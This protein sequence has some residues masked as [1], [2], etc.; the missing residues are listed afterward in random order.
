MSVLLLA[1]PPVVLML[2]A[3]RHDSFLLTCG[4]AGALF[5]SLLFVGYARIW[6]PP[7]CGSVIIITLTALAWLWFGV[8]GP[9]TSFDHLCRAILLSLAI[10]LLIAND[11]TRS[12]VEARRRAVKLCRK[13]QERT[14]WP[15]DKSEFP[16]LPEVRALRFVLQDTPESAIRLFHDPRAEVRLSLFLALQSRPYWRSNEAAAV[17]TAIK[18]ETEPDVRAEGIRTL[19]EANDTRVIA[20]V[21]GFLRDPSP[22]VR[23]AVIQTLLNGPAEKWYLVRETIRVAMADPKFNTEGALP[24]SAGILAPIATIDLFNWA[25]ENEPLGGRATAT[26]VAHYSRLLCDDLHPSL[27][28]EICQ[29]IIDPTTPPGLRIELAVMMRELGL[30]L[31]QYLDR[32]TDIDQPSPL[33]LMAVETLL[34]H[35]PANADAI[36]VLRGLARH[37]N[38]ETI[39]EVARLLQTYLRIDMGLTQRS[40]FT[41]RH[42]AEVTRLVNNWARNHKQASQ[43]QLSQLDPVPPSSESDSPAPP[44]R[45]KMGRP[46]A[47]I[48]PASGE[49]ILPKTDRIQF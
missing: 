14:W 4:A 38:R 19:A 35:D 46:P 8:Q 1:I 20:A 37:A 28:S 36:D 44:R 7:V 18:A 25:S 2:S 45:L 12:G 6:R 16:L 48:P 3:M 29:D 32:M 17:I 30:F 9:S 23:K 22:A 13:L 15:N 34:A 40:N 27:A 42:A 31:P 10:G 41:N 33:R 39:L 11:L 21:S 49:I 47:Y 43:P 26:I 24:G 5:G